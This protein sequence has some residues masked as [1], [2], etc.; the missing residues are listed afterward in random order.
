MVEMLI[1]RFDRRDWEAAMIR[2][3]Q[4]GVKVRALIAH[5][6]RGGEKSL[7]ALE[8]RLLQAGVTVSR[9]ADGNPGGSADGKGEKVAAPPFRV[10][11]DRPAP[12]RPGRYS[13]LPL[14]PKHIFAPFRGAKSREAPANLKPVGTGPYECADFKP[15]DLVRASL[16]TGRAHA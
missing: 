14:I 13:S 11:F 16:K 6:S 12:C 4:R 15:G 1:F 3:V 5:M 2:A 8:M 9:T 10:V 7:R